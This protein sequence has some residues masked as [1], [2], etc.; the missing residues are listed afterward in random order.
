MLR[1][2]SDS[3]LL[4]VLTFAFAHLPGAQ[5]MPNL[6]QRMGSES[7]FKGVPSDETDGTDG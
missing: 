1:G 7:A 2:F 3:G 5:A 6:L 4:G